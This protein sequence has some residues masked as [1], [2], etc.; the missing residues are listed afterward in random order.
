MR[1]S[2]TPELGP[3]VVDILFSVDV[4]AMKS[5]ADLEQDLYLVWPSAVVADRAAGAP[6]PAL[7]KYLSA[8][9]FDVIDSGRLTLFARNL[10]RGEHGA[11]AE[12]IAGGAPFATFVRDD[13]ALGLSAPA[14]W[15]RIP[16]NPK[17]VNRVYLMNLKMTTRGLVKDKPATWVERTFWGRRH[18]L[19]LSFNET[20]HRAVFPMYFQNRDR[21][22]RLSDEPAQL[23]INFADA[24]HLKIDEMS[25]QS[26]RRQLSETLE[27]TDTI[28][29]YLDRSEGL[30]PQVLSVQFGYFTGLQS[31]APVLIPT[32]FFVLGNVAGVLVRNVAERFS[33]RWTGRVLFARA[34]DE[35]QVKQQG[36]VIAPETLGRIVPGVTTYDEVLRLCGSDVEEQSRLTAPGRRTLVYRGRRVVPRRRRA[37]GWLATVSHWDREQHEVHIELDRDVV[38]DVQ[39]HVTRSRLNAPEPP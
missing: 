7:E 9:G 12:A 32:L 11:A 28:S 27:S 16:W 13:S 15:I 2:V 22:V 10:Y 5:A 30:T 3:I 25:P 18:R 8:R 23:I 33:K 17:F 37:F 14:T 20:R 39:V 6:D 21:V 38:S 34:K 4:P 35:P 19:S 36:A 26:A 31:W 1:A 29:L 24:D